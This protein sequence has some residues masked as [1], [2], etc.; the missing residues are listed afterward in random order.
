MTQ[1]N[2]LIIKKPWVSE[3]A[4]DLA[5]SNKYVFL[6]DEKAKSKQIKDAI[7]KIYKVHVVAMNSINI[8]HGTKKIRKAIVTLKQGE[9]IDVIPH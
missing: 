4:T 1:S 6:V 5:K 7:E 9:T 3:K 8:K 2:R